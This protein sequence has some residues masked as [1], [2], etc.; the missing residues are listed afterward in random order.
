MFR[1]ICCSTTARST[2]SDADLQA[3]IDSA[4]RFNGPKGLTGLMAYGGGQFFYVLEGS[5]QAVDEALARLKADSRQQNLRVL[6]DGE[7]EQRLFAGW[8]MAYRGMDPEA[9]RAM[10]ASVP[11]STLPTSAVVAAL[12]HPARAAEL[13]RMRLAA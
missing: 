3:L 1:Q 9:G 6:R 2:M 13:G 7:E 5:S 10:N 12:G 11:Y 8:P 4:I